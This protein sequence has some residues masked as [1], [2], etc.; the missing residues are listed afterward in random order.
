VSQVL[1]QFV[2]KLHSVWSC[3]QFCLQR[4][5]EKR[6]RWWRTDCFRQA[7]P[8]WGRSSW[9]TST[10]DGCATGPRN[11]QNSGRRRTK[12]STCVNIRNLLQLSRQVLR[13]W[14]AK[15]AVGEY[16]QPKHDAVSNL[17]PVKILQQWADAIASTGSIHQSYCESCS[18]LSYCFLMWCLITG[19]GRTFIHVCLSTL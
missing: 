8:D 6:Q 5:P 15:A 12:S 2:T 14:T 3:Q 4:L 18:Q 9:E 13:C 17:Q 11:S 1:V 7:V 19:M 10:A 16:R